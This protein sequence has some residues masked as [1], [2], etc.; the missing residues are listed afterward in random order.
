MTSAYAWRHRFV[1]PA[2]ALAALMTVAAGRRAGCRAAA[3]ATDVDAPDVEATGVWPTATPESEGLD[4]GVL[5][6]MLEHVRARQLPLHSVLIVRH[7]RLVPDATLHPFEPD[8]LHDIASATKSVTS[9]PIGIAIDKG[10]L[11]SVKQRVSDV[12]PP[13]RRPRRPIPGVNGRPSST[14]SR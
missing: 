3:D 14:C 12:L 11:T 2:A 7:G 9:V 6:E 8:R 5:A 10:R 4:S 1:I 13:L